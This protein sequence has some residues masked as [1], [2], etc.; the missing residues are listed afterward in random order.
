MYTFFMFLT[1]K[2]SRC[3]CK[4]TL[5]GPHGGVP[6]V[7]GGGSVVVDVLRRAVTLVRPVPTVGGVRHVGRTRAVRIA[8]IVGCYVAVHMALLQ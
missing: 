3:I 4:R 6:A 8:L 1:L 7:R 2:I 5:N